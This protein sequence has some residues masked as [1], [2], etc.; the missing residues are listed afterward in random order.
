MLRIGIVGLGYWGPNFMRNFS[1]LKDS[2]VTVIC[3]LN[4]ERLQ[5]AKSFLPDVHTT[6]NIDEILSKDYV[7]AVVISTPTKTH[8]ALS[9]KAL[10]NGLHVF[11]EKPLATT[12]QECEDLIELAEAKDL[13]LFV[14]HL[15]LYNEAVKKI[16]TLIDDNY[17]G[18]VSYISSKRLNLGPIRQDVNALWDLAPHD[19]SIILDFFG[20]APVAVNCQG[21]AYLNPNVHDVCALTMHFEPNSMA[22]IHVSWLD[23]NKT[24]LMTIVGEQ[25]MAVFDDNEPLEKVKIYDKR[26]E[27]PAYTDTYGEF[28]FSFQYGDT[29]SPW[30]KQVEPLKAECQHFLDCVMQETTPL[31][32]GKSGLDVVRV[33]EAAQKSLVN[34]GIPVELKR[35]ELNGYNKELAHTHSELS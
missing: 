10:E 22:I 1:N 20:R 13:I 23:P 5:Y 32:D 27:A 7:D 26:V 8:H 4:E 14:G 17:L 18:N 29:S 35:V 6:T 16:K 33:L 24:R 15:F 34:G 2:E 28:Q 30:L 9:K 31:T 11:V 19:I 21:L 3:D 25:K 12:S